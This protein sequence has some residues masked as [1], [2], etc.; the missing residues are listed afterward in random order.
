M[1][2]FNFK[3]EKI[4]KIKKDSKEKLENK[5]K[6]IN[7]LINKEINS[8]KI[9]ENKINFIRQELIEIKDNKKLNFNEMKVKNEYIQYLNEHIKNIKNYIRILEKNREI[10]INELKEEK[11][12][13]K[14]FETIKDKQYEEYKKELNKEEQ[15]LVDDNIIYKYKILNNI[16]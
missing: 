3:F 16:Y 15:R 2:N 6:E 9:A 11:K 5:I 12:E 14:K 7:N 13:V 4:L 10:L 8:I 1:K